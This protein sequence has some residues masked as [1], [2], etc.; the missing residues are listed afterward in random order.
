MSSTLQ[1]IFRTKGRSVQLGPN[2]TAS[3]ES[4]T[5]AYFVEQGR[6]AIFSV[7]LVAGAIAGARRYLCSISPGELFI[8]RVNNDVTGNVIV[9]SGASDTSIL[10]IGFQDL[11]NLTAEVGALESGAEKLDIFLATLS[12]ALPSL[13]HPKQLQL[14]LSGITVSNH[15]IGQGENCSCLTNI[16]WIE[17]LSGSLAFLGNR[18]DVMPG[19]GLFPLAPSSWVAA[20]D[21]T[22]FSS[23]ATMDVIRAGTI[24]QAVEKFLDTALQ[25]IAADE[26]VRSDTDLK[27]LQKRKELDAAGVEESLSRFSRLLTPS[28]EISG[29]HSAT[30]LL[31]VFSL[32]CRHLGMTIDFSQY[33]DSD[34]D[35]SIDDQLHKIANLAGIRT[36]KVTLEDGWWKKDCGHL[37]CFDKEGGAPIA[38]IYQPSGCYRAYTAVPGE[39]LLVSRENADSFRFFAYM[40]YR[41][42]PDTIITGRALLK[43]ALSGIRKDLGMVIV[44]GICGSVLSLTV[45]VVSGIIFD[46]VIPQAQHGQMW[47]LCVALILC[48]IGATV[49]DL[50]KQISML[51]IESRM[52]MHVQGAV[53]DR[54]L[55]LPPPFFRKYSAGD[56]ADRSMGI[57][58]IRQAFSDTIS[59]SLLAA[60]FSVTSL[61]LLFYYSYSLALIAIATAAGAVVIITSLGF[62]QVHFQKRIAEQR[63]A[64]SGK[65]LEIV[66]CIA[67]FRIAGAENRAFSRWAETFSSQQQIVMK[68]RYTG[69]LVNVF[70]EIFPVVVSMAIF[71]TI[72]SVARSAPMSIGSFLA[73]SA[74]FVQFISTLMTLGM[75][76]VSISS[77]IPSYERCKPIIESL[78]ERDAAKEHPGKLKGDIEVSGVSFK[79]NESSPPILT[80]ISLK[81]FPGEFIAI[82]GSSGSGKSTL[83]R[84]LLGFEKPESGCI[85][86]DGKDLDRLDVHQVRRQTGVVL[87]NGKLISG[88]IFDNIIGSLN[89]TIDNAWKAAEMAG[90]AEDIRNMPMGMHTFISEGG[91]NLSGGQRQRL[92]IARALISQP[93][94]L[95]FDEATSALDNK[96][97]AIVNQSLESLRVTR[98]VIA[99]RLSTIINADKIFVLDKGRVIET[100]RYDELMQLN[101]MFADLARRQVA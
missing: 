91:G 70:S 86:Y 67:K 28:K 74:A 61:A 52:D 22:E 94:V 57:S 14:D 41:S 64:L 24:I 10:E 23:A 95:I 21:D 29:V 96:T 65:V 33:T 46:T 1:E 12:A 48:A 31:A 37:I 38:L 78:P 79:Y 13:Q 9:V 19:S 39:S 27:V 26:Q 49:F 73:F 84:L 66:S 81:A 69:N 15:R 32:V 35:D 62:I 85:F 17:V 5:C 100:G 45:P 59:E 68:A 47:L 2:R 82:V 56:L 20:I 44:M 8:A 76:I 77:I 60:V 87:Q 30:P 4:G 83:V 63:G 42:F 51:R 3:P 18:H 93:A 72:I 6:A 7:P 55:K 97:Q 75:S 11:L 90:L 89:L 16:A 71:G 98:I 34:P 43:F 99:H 36:R 58:A 92:L 25:I 80:D 53:W 40:L 101:G 88:G 54:L 50:T